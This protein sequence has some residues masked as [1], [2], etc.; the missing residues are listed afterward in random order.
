MWLYSLCSACQETLL[1]A[2]SCR[3]SPPLAADAAAVTDIGVL[4]TDWRGDIFAAEVAG[5]TVVQ[6]VD[7][8]AAAA[9]TAAEA[10]AAHTG[11]AVAA[12]PAWEP[13]VAATGLGCDGVW[14]DIKTDAIWGEPRVG[15]SAVASREV[16]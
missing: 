10:R 9:A 5:L 3:L 16:G 12:A 15:G 6:V 4:V 7:Y 11:A 8:A 2:A 13:G 1:V 14:V